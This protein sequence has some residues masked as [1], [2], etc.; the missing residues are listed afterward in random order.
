MN[1]ELFEETY[2]PRW[3]QFERSLELL[4]KR[5]AL[6][7]TKD[8]QD[9][10][11]N[12]RNLCKQLALARDRR[13]SAQIVDRLNRLVIRAHRILYRDNKVESW[14]ILRFFTRT[15]PRAV[16][17]EA[18]LF[19][20]CTAIFYVPLFGLA[21][22]VHLN[23]DLIYSVM[24]AQQ[25]DQF[26]TMYDPAQKQERTAVMD[27][28][29][30]GYYIRNNVGIGFRTFGLG[31]LAGYGSIFALM[32]N[33]LVIGAL[34]GHMTHAPYYHSFFTF[35]AGHGSY[36]L[37]A[38]VLAGVA[39]MR[40][41]LA[42]IFPGNLTR[43]QALVVAGKTGIV[44]VWGMAAMLTLAAVIEAFWSPRDFAPVVKYTAAAL[45]WL[46]V[47][48]YFTFMGRGHED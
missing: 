39:G 18:R 46:S 6:I 12:Y 20:L 31:I 22:A 34:A 10:P 13:Y 45:M 24:N 8:L 17:K 11:S 43:K 21:A 23:P 36:E 3:E 38:I 44:I 47:I 19:W 25:V 15:F 5:T 28:F 48:V 1:Q 2:T 40:L 4:E 26:D 14:A 9:F 29:M 32:Y 16:R 37:T 42:F 33:G 7:E 41:G 27:F 30:F 35:V